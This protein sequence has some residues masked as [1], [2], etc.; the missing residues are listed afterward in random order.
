MG[1]IK[2]FDPDLMLYLEGLS[3]CASSDID[4]ARAALALAGARGEF[5]NSERYFNHIKKLITQA[6]EYYSE[7]LTAGADDDAGVR[8]AVLKHVL[9]EKYHYHFDEGGSCDLL[10][11]SS[12]AGLIDRGAGHSF[13]LGILYI[14]VGR[15]LNWALEPL[16]LPGVLLVR[17]DMGSQRLIFDPAQ[18]CR[19]M[20]AP[21]MRSLLKERQGED[22]ELSAQYYESVGNRKLLMALQNAV[23]FTQIAYEDYEGALATVALMR[24]IDPHELLLRLEAGVLYARTGQNILAIENL[25][26]YIEAAPQGYDRDEAVI[27]LHELMHS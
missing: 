7:L 10:V 25:E 15:S 24:K 19:I 1:V 22:A 13:V 5:Q 26:I 21:E 8:L 2:P 17:I 23:K 4:L 3:S 20:G 6:G 16:I 9:I 11:N 18:G 12:L 14:H 27:L